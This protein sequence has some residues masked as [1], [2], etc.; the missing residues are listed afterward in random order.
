METAVYFRSLRTP[1]ALKRLLFVIPPYFQIEDFTSQDRT[2]VYPQFT[3]PYGVLSLD[4]YVKQEFVGELSTKLVDFNVIL[5]ELVKD[6][7]PNKWDQIFR[8]EIET[9]VSDFMPDLV[10]ISALFNS[11]FG[12]LES[13]ASWIK[14]A[15]SPFIVAGGGL[16]SAA[17]DMVLDKCPS[18]DA[19][20][21]GEGETA[22]LELLKSENLGRTVSSFPSLVGRDCKTKIPTHNFIENLDDIPMLD[23]SI[24]GLDSYNSRSIDKRYSKDGS[25]REMSIHT[26]RGCPFSCVFCSNPSLHGKQMRYM[27]VERV[28]CEVKRMRDQFGMNVLLVE[29]DHFFSDRS[30]AKTIFRDLIELGVRVEFPNGVLVSAI[31]D[32]TALLMSS[33]G[34][35]AVALAVESGSEFVLN[36]IIKKPL[37]LKKVQPA[38]DALRKYGVKSHVFIVMGLPGELDSHREETRNML[39]HTGFDWAHIYCAIPIFGSRLYDICVENGYISD[40]SSENFVATK[41]VIRA[42]GVNPDELSKYVYE[43]QLLV[44][45]L[46]NCNLENNREESALPYFQNVVEKYPDHVLGLTRTHIALKRLNRDHDLQSNLLQRAKDALISSADWQNFLTKYRRDLDITEVSLL[47]E[48]VP[49]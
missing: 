26:S 21:K 30:R 18:I 44:N 20:C 12:Y 41:S 14:S 15:G 8:N 2:N 6:G 4:S 19:V 27:S 31:D 23:Y 45:F 24:V 22:L 25:K 7:S 34:V 5:A 48:V 42:P 3:I 13:L 11:S 35:S 37:H 47:D 32:E 1:V 38:V 29:D 33:A 10:A 49:R 39:L 16:P 36:K 43:T 46:R 17:F 40:S 28:K 9:A